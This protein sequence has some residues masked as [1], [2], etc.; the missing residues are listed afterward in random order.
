MLVWSHL[1]CMRFPSFFLTYAANL[2]ASQLDTHSS[3]FTSNLLGSQAVLA[4][5]KPITLTLC[6]SVDDDDPAPRATAVSLIKTN[7]GAVFEDFPRSPTTRYLALSP[8]PADHLRPWRRDLVRNGGRLAMTSQM[9]SISNSPENPT[10]RPPS[11]SSLTSMTQLFLI[12]RS[13]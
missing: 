1:P 8:N 4:L 11:W 12:S 10:D 6:D 9:I 13:Y 7:T 2:L 3:A 5:H